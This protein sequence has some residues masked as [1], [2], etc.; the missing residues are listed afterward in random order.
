MARYIVDTAPL[1][2]FNVVGAFMDGLTR[3]TG[4][5]AIPTSLAL[6]H[7]VNSVWAHALLSGITIGGGGLLIQLLGMTKDDWQLSAPAI[8]AGG[9]A[10]FDVYAAVIVGLFHAAL[11]RQYKELAP[12]SD[13]LAAVL[14]NDLQ[15]SGLVGQGV[16]DSEHARAMCVVLMGALLAIKAIATRPRTKR[17]PTPMKVSSAKSLK[18]GKRGSTP[19]KK[20][21]EPVVEIETKKVQQVSGGSSSA[22]VVKTPVSKGPASPRARTPKKSPKPRA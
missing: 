15:T 17:P 14:P 21:K 11:R 7:G 5:A 4:L 20:R 10:T 16:V 12:I 18:G 3:G 6:S 22:E 8:L 2:F 13:A 1:L 19:G 9:W